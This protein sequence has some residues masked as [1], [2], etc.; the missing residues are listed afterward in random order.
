MKH[1]SNPRRGRSR[2]NGRRHL[3]LKSQSFESNGPDVKVRGTAQQVLEKYLAL[4]RDASATGDRIAAES[5]L[6][7][8]E[9]YYRLLSAAEPGQQGQQGQPQFRGDRGFDRPGF[10]SDE[11]DENDSSQEEAFSG[12]P[13]TQAPTQPD[14]PQPDTDQDPPSS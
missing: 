1:S 5:Y 3:P 6:Q 11:G 10:G 7:H 8:A 4:A 13:Q 14:D 12:Q 2:N 9:H